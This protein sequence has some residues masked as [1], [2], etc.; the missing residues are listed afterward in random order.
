MM[1]GGRLE[2]RQALA[3]LVVVELPKLGR[4]RFGYEQGEVL[5]VPDA[6]GAIER[7]FMGLYAASR[8]R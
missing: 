6:S 3:P 7:I 5:F 2:G 1:N 4:E 8:S